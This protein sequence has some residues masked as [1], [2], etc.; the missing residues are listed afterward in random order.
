MA[1]L[2]A[3]DRVGIFV[4][5][6]RADSAGHAGR[7]VDQL[8]SQFGDQVFLDVDSIRPGANFQ[9]VI[10]ET[11]TKCGAVVVLIGKRW[12]EREESMP[13]F[14]DPQDIITQEIRTALDSRLP[15]VP[16]LVDGASMPAESTLPAEFTAISKLNAIDLRHT[17]FDRDVEALSEHLADVLGGAKATSIEKFLLRLYRPLVGSSFARLYGGIVLFA[18]VGVLWALAE[19]AAGA[20]GISQRGMKALV[21]PS[22]FDTD[23]LRLQAAGTAA[24]GGLLGGFFGRRSIRWWRHATLAIW[25]AVAEL[26]V[27]AALVIAYVAQ[28]PDA[29]VVELFQ[30][31]NT[32]GAP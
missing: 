3:R 4:S 14:G 11:F 27:V 18:A 26:L 10:N 20:I 15:I 23:M 24:F 29:T 2:S 21:S 7:L 9:E 25:I 31:A 28:I 13:C 6:R 22:L 19:L 5:Y 12:L 1:I 32:V 17:S 30:R 16:V 8:K